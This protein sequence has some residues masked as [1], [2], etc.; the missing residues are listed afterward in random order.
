M[1]QKEYNVKIY[2]LAGVFVRVIPGK[3]IMNPISFSESMNAGQGELRLKLALDIDSTLV[4]YN[5]VI[6]VYESDKEHTA[7]VIYTGIV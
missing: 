7:R 6:K 3:L 1:L 5:Q 4:A 2:T